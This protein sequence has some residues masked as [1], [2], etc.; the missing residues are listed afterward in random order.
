MLTLTY[1][2]VGSVVV[3]NA[4]ASAFFTTTLHTQ[5]YVGVSIL[6]NSAAHKVICER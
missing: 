4:E 6:Y 1:N 2:L 3:K 5:L